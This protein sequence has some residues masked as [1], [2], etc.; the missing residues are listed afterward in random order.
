MC[1][2]AHSV[3]LT[4]CD[5]MDCSPPGPSVHGIFQAKI[6]SGL[7]R[8]PPRDLSTQESNQLLL[9]WHVDSLPLSHL[10]SPQEQQISLKLS[11][12]DTPRKTLYTVR[13]HLTS[14]P[15][16]IQALATVPSIQQPLDMLPAY[17]KI[18]QHLK[19]TIPQTDDT[20]EVHKNHMQPVVTWIEQ[21]QN[22]CIVTERPFGQH[23]SKKT[24]AQISLTILLRLNTGK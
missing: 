4:L 14:E 24:Q 11:V 8:P 20:F 7:P 18:K 10:G 21:I 23:W 2:C 9:H 19:N 22:N 5:P 1:T 13:P 12:P 6:W 17:I 16:K 15:L 3:V